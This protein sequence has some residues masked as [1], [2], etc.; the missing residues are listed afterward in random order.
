MSKS[1][2]S[3]RCYDFFRYKELSSIPFMAHLKK[4]PYVFTSLR[5]LSLNDTLYAIDENNSQ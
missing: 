5:F 4:T 3:E 1:Y 2:T